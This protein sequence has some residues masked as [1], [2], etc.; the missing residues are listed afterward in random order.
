MVSYIID[1]QNSLFDTVHTILWCF[2]LKPTPIQLNPQPNIYKKCQNLISSICTI[3]VH[4]QV[5]QC[6]STLACFRY[7]GIYC[8]HFSLTVLQVIGGRGCAISATMSTCAP[9]TIKGSFVLLRAT[10]SL[11]SFYFSVLSHSQTTLS[12]HQLKYIL[13]LNIPLLLTLLFVIY[14]TKIFP[15]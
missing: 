8:L 6:D 9:S 13:H 5:V 1:L 12:K 15:A 7:L 11:W 4:L 14:V 10:L 2:C 3:H